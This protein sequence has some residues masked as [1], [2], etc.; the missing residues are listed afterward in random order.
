MSTFLASL[1][2]E[3]PHDAVP[4]RIVGH[5]SLAERSPQPGLKDRRQLDLVVREKDRPVAHRA[6]NAVIK[7]EINLEG[8]VIHR[9]R[10]IETAFECALAG[11]SPSE[12]C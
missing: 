2:D 3:W 6:L 12:F 5:R 1:T 11:E 4:K 8:F 7:A 10:T 9:D